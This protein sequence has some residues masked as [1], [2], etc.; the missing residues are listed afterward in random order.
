VVPRWVTTMS[1]G[2]DHRLIDGEE[3]STFLHD[4]AEILSDPASAMLY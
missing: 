4:V 2:F 3:G 1:L